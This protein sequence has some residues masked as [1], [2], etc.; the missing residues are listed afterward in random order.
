MV[1]EVAAWP[2][3]KPE[4]MERL[5]NESGISW[6]V[7]GDKTVQTHVHRDARTVDRI[8]ASIRRMSAVGGGQTRHMVAGGWLQRS[9]GVQA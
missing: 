2:N 7:S 3:V 8:T 5:L 1:V 6:P 9:A 4:T